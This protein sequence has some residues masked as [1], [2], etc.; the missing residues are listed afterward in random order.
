MRVMAIVWN[1]TL[2]VHSLRV[3]ISSFPR[4][5][6]HV[7]YTFDLAKHGGDGLADEGN[8]AEDASLSD[9]DVEQDLVGSDELDRR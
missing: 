6:T 8:L 7:D 4:G 9:K 2:A 3:Y 1:F 5:N